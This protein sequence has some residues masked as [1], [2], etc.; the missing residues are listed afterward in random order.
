MWYDKRENLTKFRLLEDAG[1]RSCACSKCPFLP[2]MG[3][4]ELQLHL[5]VAHP[6]GK[7]QLRLFS[8]EQI[9][10]MQSFRFKSQTI[11][12]CTLKL[13]RESPRVRKKIQ[14]V[15][16]FLWCVP[17]KLARIS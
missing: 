6:T 11:Q 4:D 10:F 9:K 16:F 17:Q 12:K 3:L 13:F 14:S 2:P 8:A 15:F 5:Q 1:D 7:G